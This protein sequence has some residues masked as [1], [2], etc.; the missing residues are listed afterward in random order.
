MQIERG[1]TFI[2]P[3]LDFQ[4]FSHERSFSMERFQ[5]SRMIDVVKE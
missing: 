1:K 3:L 2:E 4:H 5:P